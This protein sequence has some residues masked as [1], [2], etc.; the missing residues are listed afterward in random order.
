MATIINIPKSTSLR[1]VKQGS[2][3]TFDNTLLE[4]ESYYAYVMMRS[5][6]HQKLT[7]TDNIWIQFS[8][9]AATIKF[10]LFDSDDVLIDDLT[11]QI[12]TVIASTSYTVYN[13]RFNVTT[14]GN[15]YIKATFDS[16]LYFS[17]PFKIG[18]FSN[19][20]LLKYKTSENDGVVYDDDEYFFLRI[21]GRFAEYMPGSERTT[22]NSF[23]QTI[24]NLKAYPTAS[25]LLEFGA[26]PRYVL[27]KL[28][29][30]LAH[31]IVSIN[32]VEY[33]QKDN[34]NASMLRGDYLV[35]EMYKGSVMMRQVDYENY[36]SV[37]E[38]VPV[39]TYFIDI[40][41]T[42]D[43]LLINATDKIIYKD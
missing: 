11:S 43:N 27:E 4:S 23:N 35:T 19:T 20:V 40:N 17:E 16:D 5:L 1:F 39:E 41:T 29:I 21:E 7:I 18:T 24:V 25:Y 15:Y 10:E 33:Q 2:P 37:V 13:L 28:N 6:Y 8:T 9:D 22:Y 38:D 32:G 36:D 12:V 14:L 3:Q 34:I 30:A 42:G 26:I 31:E